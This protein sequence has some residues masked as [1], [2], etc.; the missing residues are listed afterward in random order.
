MIRVKIYH[1][2]RLLFRYIKLER[3]RLLRITPIWY[4]FL[5][6]HTVFVTPIEQTVILLIEATKNYI[7]SNYSK[8]ISV[9]DIAGAAYMSASHF[10]KV[11]WETTG[12]SPYDYLLTIRL[13]KAK[14][15][16]L[17]TDDPIESI[18][19]K[20]GFNSASNFIY[21]FKKETSLSP[22]KFRNM[23]F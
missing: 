12:F 23:K 8:N 16:L 13:D 10:S 22:L 7:T 2:I 14:E 9:A 19:G 4:F 5:N 20:T 11:F 18:A 15:L 1:F 6:K 17:Q 21:F 3:R